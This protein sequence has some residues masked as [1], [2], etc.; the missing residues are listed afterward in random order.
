MKEFYAVLCSTLGTAL[1]GII[2]FL[3]KKVSDFINSKIEDKKTAKIV[4][5]INTIFFNAVTLVTQTFVDDL[6]KNGTFTEEGKTKAKQMAFDLIFN[7]LTQEMKEYIEK[8]YNI[9]INTFI[10]N[11]IESTIYTLKR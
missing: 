9:D 4:S 2:G 6:K 5:N 8:T 7:Q 1:L 11:K 3:G 10:Y